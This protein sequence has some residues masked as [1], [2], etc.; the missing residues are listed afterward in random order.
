MRRTSEPTL[1][2]LA[3]LAAAGV[4]QCAGCSSEP[5]DR[6]PSDTIVLV[7]ALGDS[8]R[9]PASPRRVV[10]LAPGITEMV[11]ALGQEDRL[12]GVTEFCDYPPE[13]ADKP[14]VSGYNMINH[15]AILAAQPDVTLAARGNPLEELVKLR[16]MGVTVI[17][18]DQGTV[19][20]AP[21]PVGQTVDL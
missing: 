11:Y 20:E 19:D 17:T 6:F 10:S 16:R 18:A 5:S 2:L 7:D 15:E 9:L 12:V 4:L 3:V 21:P 14:R 8:V 13:A 1:A